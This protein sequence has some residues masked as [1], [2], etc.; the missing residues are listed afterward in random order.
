MVL[1]DEPAD[2]TGLAHLVAEGVDHATAPAGVARF[3]A[4]GLGQALREGMGDSGE[5]TAAQ[6]FYTRCGTADVIFCSVRTRP[7]GRRL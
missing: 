5:I 4:P 6:S 7:L 3:L 2:L 1:D